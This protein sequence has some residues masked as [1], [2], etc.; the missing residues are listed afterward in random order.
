MS[1]VVSLFC[2]PKFCLRVGDREFFVF[3]K[4]I[5]LLMKSVSHALEGEVSEGEVLQIGGGL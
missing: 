4:N 3:L 1:L 5:L 2:F